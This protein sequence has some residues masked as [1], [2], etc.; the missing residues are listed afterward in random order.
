MVFINAKLVSE[1]STRNRRKR[2]NVY[3]DSNKIAA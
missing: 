2:V 1:Y 3:L